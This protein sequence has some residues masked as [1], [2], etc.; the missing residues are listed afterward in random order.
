M[1]LSPEV[2]EL[3]AVERRRLAAQLVWTLAVPPFA[4]VE[5]LVDGERFDVPGADAVQDPSD[6]EDFDPDG[7][8]ADEKPLLY[9]VQD[10]ALRTLG[11]PVLPDSE[12]TQPAGLSVEEVAA[13]PE[14]G[15]LALLS[16]DP[17]G[18][19]LRVG[20]PEGPFVEA[21]TKSDLTSPSWGPGTQGV[22]VLEPGP[23]PILWLVPGPDA[24]ADARPVPVRYPQPEG[25][26]RLSRVQVSR[27][28]ARIAL[29]FG[30]GA[31]RR[32]HIGVV[33]PA[34]GQLQVTGIDPVAPSQRDVTDVAWASGTSLVMLASAGQD[35]TLLLWTVTVDGSVA[36]VPVPKP[37]LPSDARSVAAMPGQP[38]VVAAEVDGQPT[39]FRD[40]GN[41][42]RELETGSAPAYPG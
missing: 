41:T 15:A 16:R 1:E 4:G 14:D 26:G 8:G 29:V 12:A 40:N 34:A 10:G 35:P 25:A 22:W 24:P 2:L 19:V 31:A 5:L 36:P 21:L 33:E 17:G 30:E 13:S 39:L 37:G 11:P 3:V 27:D 7:S 9:Y 32:L 18:A 23:R 42:F 28:G 20:L 38:L 6:W